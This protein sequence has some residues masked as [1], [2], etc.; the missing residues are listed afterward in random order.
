MKYIVTADEMRKCDQN[1]TEFLKIPAMVLMERAAL[2]VLKHIKERFSHKEPSD[3]SA[4][5]FCGVGNNGGDGLAL[6]R[7]MADA[8]YLVEVCI[9]GD[10]TR[11]SSG[12]KNQ[13]DILQHYNIK[14]GSNLPEGE[15]TIL[16]DALLGVGIS[17]DI[18]GAFEQAIHWFNSHQGYKLAIDIPSGIHTDTGAILHCAV[19]V[20]TTVTFGFLKR[21][22]ILAPGC[23]HAGRVICEDIGIREK[24]FLGKK[25]GMFTYDETISQLLPQRDPLGN[26]GTFGKVL[27]IAGSDKMVGAAALCAK[28]C[29]RTGAGMV[30]VLSH[31]DNR[32]PLTALVPEVLPGTLEELKDGLAWADVIVFGPGCGQSQEMREYLCYCL[33]CSDLPLIIDADGI[34]I[35]SAQEDLIELLKQQGEKGRTLILTPHMGELSRLTGTKMAA[36]KNAMPG[37]AKY[38]A[39]QLKCTLVAKDAITFTGNEHYSICTSFCCNSGLATAGSG[40]VLTGIIAGL[41]AQGL[42]GFEAA[43]K[44]VAIHALAGAQACERC[45]VHGCMA[46]DIVEA[47]CVNEQM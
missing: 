38:W 17:R 12:W 25:P 11:S 23:V 37:A 18:S 3:V 2:S 26:K 27:M 30:K 14:I 21:G 39:T 4:L 19:K 8:G 13:Y 36:L 33:K 35:L 22:L 46:S 24:S 42:S 32:M 44:G 47:L 34:N 15:Y 5:I 43:S 29:Y 7:L 40:D 28:A 10:K 1:T 6:A 31:P 20:D 45:G 41:T 16:I 9:L